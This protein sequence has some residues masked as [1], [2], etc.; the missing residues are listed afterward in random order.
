M[1]FDLQSA[2]QGAVGTLAG[3]KE[4]KIYDEELERIRRKELREKAQFDWDR[5][6]DEQL[7]GIQRQ[8]TGLREREQALAE[9]KLSKQLTP[10]EEARQKAVGQG[11]GEVEAYL[12][13]PEPIRGKLYPNRQL[14]VEDREWNITQK[15]VEQW[16]DQEKRWMS[17]RGYDVKTGLKKEGS[18]KSDYGQALNNATYEY[19]LRGA[20]EKQNN[21]N[22]VDL[23]NMATEIQAGNMQISQEADVLKQIIQAKKKNKKLKIDW[24][25]MSTKYPDLDISAV[26]TGLKSLGY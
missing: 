6:K 15:P 12:G 25:G 13:T 17:S 22:R 10:E 3:F 9:E 2:L 18:A 8:N 5:F 16:T 14:T 4:K 11:K 26:Q 23:H 7:L 20:S 1:A 21:L 19:A 24:Q